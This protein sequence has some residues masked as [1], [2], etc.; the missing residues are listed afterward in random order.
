MKKYTYTKNELAKQLDIQTYILALWEKQ[1]GIEVSI[2][3]GEP[4]YSQENYDFI[5][6]IKELLYEKGYTIQEAKKI[7]KVQSTVFE[8][9]II[10]ASI[11]NL[12]QSP[13]QSLKKELLV[14]KQQLIQLRKHL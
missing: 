12:P 6:S 8:Q 2:E 5:A 7:L 3:Q 9:P 14:L 1:F 4:R 13:S 10:A 11:L